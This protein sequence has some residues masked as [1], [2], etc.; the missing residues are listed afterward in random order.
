VRHDGVHSGKEH[1]EHANL[2]DDEFDLGKPVAE[3]R[4][5]IVGMAAL[6]H[7]NL[8]PASCLPAAN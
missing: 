5:R 8:L 2:E 4:E 6:R 3:L 7:T 1:D